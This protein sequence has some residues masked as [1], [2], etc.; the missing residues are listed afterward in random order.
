MSQR[1]PA[2]DPGMQP[3]WEAVAASALPLAMVDHAT[4]DLL[5]VNPAYA[6]AR[7][8]TPEEMVGMNLGRVLGPSMAFRLEEIRRNLESQGHLVFE[9]VNVRKD[10]STFPVLV[11]ATLVRDPGG[12]PRTRIVY[13]RDITEIKKA[14][15]ARQK[16]AAFLRTL[17]DTLPDLI[18]LKDPEGV[19]LECNPRFERFFGAPKG[20][21][22]GR[23]DYDFVDKALADFF[24]DQDRRALA[25]GRP[26]V[27]EEEITFRDDGHRESLETIKTPILGPDGRPIGVL[28]I[29]RDI[30]DRK[31]AEDQLRISEEKYH[32]AFHN[33]PLLASLSRLED[34]LILEVNDRYCQMLG[35]QREE[36]VGRT[37]VELGVFEPEVRGRMIAALERSR[38]VQNLELPIRSRDGQ[39]IPCLFFAEPFHAGG[40]R[41]LLVMALDNRERRTAEELQR[42]LDA[43]RNQ[44][45]KLDSLG[46]LASGV[47]H[48]MNNVLGA[49]Q[50]M[51][52]T[53]AAHVAGDPFL[54]DRFA[55][56]ERACARGRDLVKGLTHF[57]RKDL[58]EP[59][60]LDLNAMVAEEMDLLARTTLQKVHLVM[61]LE[62][63]LPKVMGEGGTLSSALMN[64]CVNAVDAMPGGGTLTLRTR[65]VPPGTVEVHVEDSGEG[66]SEGVLARAM[67]PFFTTKPIGKGTGMGLSMAYATLKAHGGNLSI[68]SAP[69]QGTRVTLSLPAGTG[70][71]APAPAAPSAPPSPGPLRI[72]LVDD[73]PLILST[74]PDLLEVLGHA[75]ATASNGPAALARIGSGDD[76]DLVI[77]DLNMP[78]M[79]GVETLK[80]LRRLRPRL[81]VLLATGFLDEATGEL[82][83]R[84]GR[85]LSILKPFSKAHLAR[86]ITEIT[87]LGS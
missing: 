25:T 21:I 63:S 40:E 17:L 60:W 69:G 13:A 52:E 2:P 12:A 42:K 37:S 70:G 6:Q 24:R 77:L 57:A 68:R 87:A 86:R 75:V 16:S 36:V 10:G 39:V 9:T 59:E 71:Q 81:P 76:L 44:M 48:D 78:G 28:G 65:T 85:A 61:D 46:S 41:F 31:R 11:D 55:L 45:Q 50:A 14:E 83:E 35:F 49:I 33:S 47:A 43:E 5:Q 84:D 3:S 73:D 15:G 20:E 58:R 19:Y 72:L 66:M 29:G 79:N 56:I 62:P 53:V 4:G 54:A 74:I 64:L 30:T 34:G 27:N 51:T 22:L 32:K 26:T 18:W 23:T 38:S 80:G 1:T 67:E 82:L 7:G 8:Y